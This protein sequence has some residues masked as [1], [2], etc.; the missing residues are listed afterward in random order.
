MTPISGL[1]AFRVYDID[2]VT[3]GV[4]DVTTYVANMSDPSFQTPEGPVWTKYY[5]ARET[6]GALVDPPL[7][8]LRT[9]D[10]K[11]EELIREL[12]PVFWHEV[13]EAFEQNPAALDEFI[14]RKR[15][16]W[17]PSVCDDDACRDA[18]ICKLRAGRAQDN[19]ISPGLIRLVGKLDEDAPAP[20]ATK[21]GEQ[22]ECGGSVLADTLGSVAG[23]PETRAWL[24][25][26]INDDYDGRI[27]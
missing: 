23:D 20:H 14:A 6:Y 16:G 22:Q 11:S 2:P 1:P 18:E 19:C 7:I 15:R 26:L 10:G 24:E 4:L 13:T 27:L 3:F 8:P 5:S 25:M 21:L 17:Q 9:E 12:D